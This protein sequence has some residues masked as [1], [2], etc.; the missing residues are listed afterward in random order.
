MQRPYVVPALIREARSTVR[1]LPLAATAALLLAVPVAATA[2]V[3]PANSYYVPEAGAGPVPVTGTAAVKFFRACP[4]NDGGSSL[5]NHAR[6]KIVLKNSANAGVGGLIPYIKFR[7]GTVAQGFTMGSGA[8][9]IIANPTYCSFTTTPCPLVQQIF[10]D[11]PTD[12]STGETWLTFDGS[13]CPTCMGF[14]CTPACPR[15]TGRKW[16]HYDCEIPVYVMDGGVE[17]KILGK[18]LESDPNTPQFDCQ[19]GGSLLTYGFV[20]RIKNFDLAGGLGAVLGQSEIV[21]VLDFNAIANSI[22]APPNAVSFWR[23]LDWSGYTP[24]ICI[25]NPPPAN[26]NITTTDL[27]IVVGHLNHECDRPNDP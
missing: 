1:A 4:N 11:G 26:N 16:G 5:P 8:D 24:P 2:Q 18:L 20:L 13:G 6:I 22:G 17:V 14:G 7:G 3:D 9:S 23:D 21:S 12:P 10:A 19:C 25:T 15:D 27:N